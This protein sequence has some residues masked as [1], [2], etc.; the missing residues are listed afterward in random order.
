VSEV[1]TL[2]DGA[3]RL[4]QNVSKGLPLHTPYSPKR[5]HFSCLNNS[6]PLVDLLLMLLH[7]QNDF[8]FFRKRDVDI[9]SEIVLIQRD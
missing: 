6:E 8:S 4:S 7:N 2:E 9:C 3:I 5:L 1:L